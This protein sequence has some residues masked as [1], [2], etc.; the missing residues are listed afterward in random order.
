MMN[1]KREVY[2]DNASTTPIDKAVTKEVLYYMEH[3]F[4]NPSSLYSEGRKAKAVLDRSRSKVA[5]LIG[6]RADEVIFT[7]SGTESDNL[8]IFGVARAYKEKGKH[9]IVSKIEHKAV[10]ESA[11]QLGKEGFRVTYLDVN[12]DGLVDLKEL[13]S[14]ICKDTILISIIHANNEVGTIQPIK[15]ISKLV[16]EIRKGGMIPILHTDSCQ[17]VGALPLD[18]KDSGVDLMTINGSKIYGPK[19]IGV[20]YKSR[21]VTIKPIIFGGGQEKGMRS[22][23]ENIALA[24]GFAKALEIS[25]KNREEESKRLSRLRDTLYKGILK[26]IDF[27][28]LNGHP[29]ERLP[30]NLN[31]SFLNVEG[32][33]IMLMLDREGISVSTGS[34]C[35]STNLNPSHVILAMGYPAE[36]AHASIRFTLGRHT[37]EEDIKYTLDKL[38]FIIKKLRAIT[39]PT[40]KWT[41]K[42]KKTPERM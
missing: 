23:T 42:T 32:E 29:T 25:E 26:K 37:S 27:V 22:G 2:L 7:G 21:E 6:A 8:A 31:V 1:Q 16:R 18:V 40:Y 14:K 3:C 17:A 24:A 34:A 19:G 4:G 10:L 39:V 28:E 35:A 20:L 33:A 5:K 13:K 38:S 30:N 15:K 36:R 11:L 9:I 41:N 12:R